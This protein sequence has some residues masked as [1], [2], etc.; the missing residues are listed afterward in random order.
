MNTAIYSPAAYWPAWQRGSGLLLVLVLLDCLGAGALLQAGFLVISATHGPNSH[1]ATERS[2][3]VVVIGWAIG[4]TGHL[5]ALQ[6]TA[7]RHQKSEATVLLTSSLLLTGLCQ[8]VMAFV[9]YA[10]TVVEVL[11]AVFNP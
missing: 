8:L 5:V 3:W 2:A 10:A 1:D 4:I 11:R 7:K 6:R 9:L